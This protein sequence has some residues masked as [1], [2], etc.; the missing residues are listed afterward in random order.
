MEETEEEHR[1]RQEMV[2]TQIMARG[3]TDP[4]VVAAMRAV[5]RHLFVPE[6]WQ[7]QA[8]LDTPLP[9]GEGQTISQPYIVALMTA[10]LSLKSTDRVLEIGT[11]S[12]YQAAILGMLAAEVIS[13]ERIAV[14]AAR[15]EEH[16]RQTG[17]TNV[18]VLV[19]DGTGGYPPAAP[20]DAIL[21]TAGT[22]TVPPP[23]LAQLAD[24]GRLVAPVGGQDVQ[25]LVLIKRE[26]D[27]YRE[28][29]EGAVRFVPL[30]GEHG[31]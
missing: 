17:I 22:P 14:V 3:V 25:E 1:A 2:S 28:Y 7:R 13:I 16:L 18:T 24:H 19:Q 9:I 11:G 27:Q 26:G 4:R 31:W 30:I 10:L 29:P 8:Y 23:L 15:A 20:Y 5:P 12:G 21:V 6:G